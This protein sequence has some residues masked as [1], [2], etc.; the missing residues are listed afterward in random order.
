MTANDAN[1]SSVIEPIGVSSVIGR[2][3][4]ILGKD[5]VAACTV[6]PAGTFKRNMASWIPFG[7]LFARRKRKL[8][9]LMTLALTRDRLHL[10]KVTWT[11][12][13]QH[14]GDWPVT[15][16]HVSV[17]PGKVMA[18]LAMDTE[19]LG[20]LEVEVRI[21]GVSSS[22]NKAFLEVLARSV[23]GGYNWKL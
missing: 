21:W 14:I 6:E 17:I 2:V 8:P 18:T 22:E 4:P 7:S 15:A 1:G 12:K 3:R 9:R 5:L 11:G 10:Y 20:L 16:I 19:D 13:V 23:P